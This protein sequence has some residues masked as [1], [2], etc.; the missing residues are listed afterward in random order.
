MEM[1]EEMNSNE[2]IPGV[3]NVRLTKI[4]DNYTR[5]NF[6][7][8]N[9]RNDAKLADIRNFHLNINGNKI[10]RLQEIGSKPSEAGWVDIEFH[11]WD[12]ICKFNNIL[13]ERTYTPS[14]TISIDC[15]A[16]NPNWRWKE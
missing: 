8:V 1:G 4:K 5:I 14:E 7:S 9:G 15:I 6:T 10:K 11:N 3:I 13:S 2:W 16:I 12:N